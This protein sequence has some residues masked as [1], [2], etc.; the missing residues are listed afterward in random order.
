MPDYRPEYIFGIAILD[1]RATIATHDGALIYLPFTGVCDL[2]PSGYDG[3]L[4]GTLPQ[5]SDDPGGTPLPDL[6][7]ELFLG[8]TACKCLNVGDVDLGTG[9]LRYDVYAT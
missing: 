7:P 6:S 4:N 5:K 2:G 1:V 3:F 9:L 8:S